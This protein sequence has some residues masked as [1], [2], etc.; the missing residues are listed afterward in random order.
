[1]ID[2]RYKAEVMVYCFVSIIAMVSIIKT[3]ELL[4]AVSP[5]S[6]RL[7]NRCIEG[8]QD[9]DLQAVVSVFP[10]LG[11]IVFERSFEEL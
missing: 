4:C 5:G 9:K 3:Y 6:F 7:P 11:G 8:F 10:F 1:M 2:S